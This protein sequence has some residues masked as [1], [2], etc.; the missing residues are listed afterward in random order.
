MLTQVWLRLPRRLPQWGG[1]ST[2][3]EP[4]QNPALQERPQNEVG[5]RN[6]TECFFMTCPLDCSPA[7][8]RKISASWAGSGWQQV[9]DAGHVVSDFEMPPQGKGVVTSV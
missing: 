2:L 7:K 9:P 5:N 8:D 1:V 4:I 6:G 3:P